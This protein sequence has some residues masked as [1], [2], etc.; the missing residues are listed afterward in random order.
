MATTADET[1]TVIEALL[2]LGT[3]LPVPNT[4]LDENATL[5]PLAPEPIAIQSSTTG[6]SVKKDY[7]GTLPKATQPDAKKKKTFVT[8]EYKLKRKYVN[9]SRKFPCEKCR[10]I[11]YSQR[12]VNEHFRTSHPPVQCD[13]CEKHLIPQ[14]QWL[15][16]GTTTTSICT[17]VT[18]A[19]R[20]SILKAS[21]GSIYG[22]TRH[23]GIGLVFARSV[24]KDSNANPS[25]MCT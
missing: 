8:V 22:S 24:A 23:K 7:E 15:N 6:T 19:E 4:D 5:V 3:D 9:T 17:S 18:T 12:E 25:W 16:T 20:D 14:Q 21:W 11:F 13:M 1:Q 2:S 10:T